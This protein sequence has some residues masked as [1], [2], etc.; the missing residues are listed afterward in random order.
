[1][2]NLFIMKHINFNDPQ[3]KK[4]VFDINI[5]QFEVIEQ[6]YNKGINKEFED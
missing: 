5:N 2:F 3:S 1:M 6:L 4:K